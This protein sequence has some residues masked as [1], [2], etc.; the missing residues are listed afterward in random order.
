MATSYA[1]SSLD[2]S[3]ILPMMMFY[4]ATGGH[5]YTGLSNRNQSFIDLTHLLKAGRAILLGRATA[6][7][8]LLRGNDQMLTGTDG[9]TWVWYRYVLPVRAV[10]KKRAAGRD[11][12]QE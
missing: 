2:V 5:G 6:P 11:T 3:R 9:K 8:T 10:G 1:Q 7:G 4:E 12:S